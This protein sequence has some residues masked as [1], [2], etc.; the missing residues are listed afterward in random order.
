[1]N[2]TEINKIFK[3]PNNDKM[4]AAAAAPS[5]GG[6]KGVIAGCYLFIYQQLLTKF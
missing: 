5:V 1:M 2:N 4:L 3:R 6:L